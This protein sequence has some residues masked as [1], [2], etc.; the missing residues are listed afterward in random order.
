MTDLRAIQSE[1]TS[2]FARAAFHDLG[3]AEFGV[4][5]LDGSTSWGAH[6]SGRIV[7]PQGKQSV[8]LPIAYDEREAPYVVGADGNEAPNLLVSLSDEGERIACAWARTSAG[9]PLVGVG[10]DLASAEDFDERP[11]M[12]RIT[13]LL[14]T[15][16]EHDIA[17]SLASE[18]GSLETA[19]AVLFGAKEA[20]FKAMARP[21]RTWYRHHDDEL[22]FEVRHYCMVEPGTE[23]GEARNGAAQAAM[24]RMGI[25]H[26][27]V[28]HVIV[29][30]MALVVALALGT[31]IPTEDED[32]T[33]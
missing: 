15:E 1:T 19:H 3:C 8:A 10:I 18:T 14:F 5:V 25:R 12:E 33:S 11:G 30:D 17:R 16:R 7:V 23:R 9:S 24:D 22:A 4:A 28:R 21:L 31:T 6:E 32:G 13:R 29:C 2:S 20:S 27:E 26:I